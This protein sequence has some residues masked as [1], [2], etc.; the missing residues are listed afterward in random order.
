MAGYHDIGP[1]LL[2]SSLCMLHFRTILPDS[3]NQAPSTRRTPCMILK[4]VI[5]V[6]KSGMV[7]STLVATCPAGEESTEHSNLVTIDIENLFDNNA[8]IDN[9]SV[10]LRRKQAVVRA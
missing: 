10:M 5:P 4:Q 3:S 9:D 6:L 8:V 7:Q 1:P 2:E